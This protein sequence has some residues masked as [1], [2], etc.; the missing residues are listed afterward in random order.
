MGTLMDIKQYGVDVDDPLDAE[1]D[2][3]VMYSGWTP[4]V[5]EVKQ[6]YGKHVA[7]PAEFYAGDEDLLLQDVYIGRE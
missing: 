3:E 6:G 1:Y 2:E 4:A 7:M 5:A